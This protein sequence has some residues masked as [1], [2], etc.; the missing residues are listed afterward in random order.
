[1]T[2]NDCPEAEKAIGMTSSL[3]QEATTAP[4]FNI[5]LSQPSNPYYRHHV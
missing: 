5:E 3:A 1:M 4:S 2:H